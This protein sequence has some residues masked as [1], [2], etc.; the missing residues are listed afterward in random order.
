MTSTPIWVIE[1]CHDYDDN[2]ETTMAFTCGDTA[3]QVLA[4]LQSRARQGFEGTFYRA[5]LL[6]A[7]EVK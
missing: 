5:R 2:W 4:K 7:E 6:P 1:R 3:A